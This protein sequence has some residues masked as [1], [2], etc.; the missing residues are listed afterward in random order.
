[1]CLWRNHTTGCPAATSTHLTNPTPNHLTTK[2]QM[3]AIQSVQATMAHTQGAMAATKTSYA[4]A[5]MARNATGR[6]EPEAGWA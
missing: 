2:P 4:A 6:V 3:G 5:V 1:V